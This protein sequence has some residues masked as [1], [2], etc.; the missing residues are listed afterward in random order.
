MVD[1]LLFTTAVSTILSFPVIL[2]PARVSTDRLL[3]LDRPPSYLRFILE[4][5]AILALSFLIAIAI[6]SFSTVLGLF[7]SLTNTCIGYVLPPLYYLKLH[8]TPLKDSYMKKLAI[9]LLIGGS[10]LGLIA[11]GI[12]TQDYIS[13][14]LK[15]SNPEGS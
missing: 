4:A 2:W 1:I 15:G 6:P 7:G 8:P 11:A 5:A 12:I 13:S 10:L 3:F 9:A 14:L